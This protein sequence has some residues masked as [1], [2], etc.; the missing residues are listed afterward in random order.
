M[1]VCVLHA[2]ERV[3]TELCVCLYVFACTSGCTGCTHVYVARSCACVC[4][5]VCL[6]VCVC[7]SSS[8][9]SPGREQHERQ[10]PRYKVDRHPRS[11][12]D[13]RKK[14]GHLPRVQ[15]TAKQDLVTQ[16]SASVWPPQMHPT[17][18]VEDSGLQ[19]THRTGGRSLPGAWPA[20]EWGGLGAWG[21]GGGAIVWICWSGLGLRRRAWA[22]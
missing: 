13:R 9:A 4:V 3:R 1:F 6:C 10:R 5:S 20:D 8:T 17:D 15:P 19:C 12:Q 11:P 16:P 14:K 7:A 22:G 2:C 21:L 18:A